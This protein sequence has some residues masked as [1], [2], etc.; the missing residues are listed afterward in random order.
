[1]HGNANGQVNGAME[2]IPGWVWWLLVLGATLALAACGLQRRNNNRFEERPITLFDYGL[3]DLGVTDVNTDDRLDVFTVNHSG[4]QS[5]L[6]NNGAGRFEEIFPSMKMDQDQTFPGMAVAAVEPLLDQP[7][8]YVYWS[9]P[10]IVVR[11]V[12]P[13]PS[14]PV[15]GQITLLSPID[16]TEKK[17]F[18]AVVST[19]ALASGATQSTIAFN[20]QG[21]GHFAFRPYIHA[22]PI[23]FQ[24]ETGMLPKAVYV[25]LNRI[26]PDAL[27][28]AITMRD[29]HGMAWVD[30][31]HDNRMDVFITRGG[32]RGTMSTIPMDFWDE[33][34][35]SSPTVMEEVGGLKGLVKDGCPGRQAAWVDYNADSRLDIYVTCGREK[36]EG[37]FPNKLFQQTPQGHFADVAAQVGL[38]LQSDGTFLWVDADL[39]GDMDLFWSDEAGFSLYRNEPENFIAVRIEAGFRHGRSD[40]ISMADYDNDGD[41]DLFSAS[42][43]GNA[44]LVNTKGTFSAVDPSTVG[45]PGTS[46]TA[47]WVD[48]DNDGWMDLHAIPG[49]VFKQ[50]PKGT[51]VAASTLDVKHGRFSPYR[52]AGARAAWFDADGNGTRDLLVA[53]EYVMKNTKWAQWAARITGGEER[54]GK[55]RYFWESRLFLNKS[56]ANHWLQVQLVGP[57]S[58]RQAI[59]ARVSVA[60]PRGE[61]MQQVGGAEGSHYSQGHYRLYFGLGDHPNASKITVTWPDGQTTEIHDPAGDR[62]L[63]IS[64]EE[65]R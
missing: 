63:T 14:Q 64:A 8:L 57:P 34:F 52:L 25:G 43:D 37:V 54:F 60:T 13:D 29:R 48:V 36:N 47:N 41:M 49:G 61:S 10:D 15:A 39:D 21:P 28:F 4:R 62:L 59:G 26:S 65:P 32:L 35:V 42:S 45:L 9:G 33:L 23:R 56:V 1:M 5:V 19:Q 18:T 40:K 46:H 58:N 16:I 20:G 17:N 38:D 30:L 53:N 27:D 51:F 55:M 31:N 22:L 50:T 11:T 7:G 2:A 24:V 6:L 3:F 12:G 44:L